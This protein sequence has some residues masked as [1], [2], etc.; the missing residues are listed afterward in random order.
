MNKVTDAA[1]LTKKQIHFSIYVIAILFFVIGFIS[2][3][4]SILIPYF[5]IVCEL[6][7]FEAYFV[8][9]SFYI[10]YLIISFPSSY[11]LKRV[12]YK[13]GIMIAFWIMS[14]GA[15]IFIPAAL[16]RAYG[17][18][19]LG[20]FTL[21]TGLA[22][23]QTA[24]NPYITILG[25]MD[26]AARRI[27][28][29][30]LCN[31]GAGILAPLVF[32]AVILHSID[33]NFFK[34]LPLLTGAQK[35]QVLANLSH[36]L[37]IPYTV[38]GFVLLLLGIAVLFSPLPEIGIND[39]DRPDMTES[40]KRNI[41]DFPYLI[42][43]AIAIFLH[44]GTQVIS[45]DT[46]IGYA[47]SMHIS[48][49]EA[50][51]FPSYTLSATILG[52]LIGVITIPRYIS[53]K[54]AFQVCTILGAVLSLAIVMLK[55]TVVFLGHRSDISLWFVCLLGLANSLIWAGIWPLALRGLGKFTKS[56]ASILIM[57]LCGNALL[58]LLYGR[59]ADVFGLR[60]AYWLLFPCYLYLIFYV[61][62]GYRINKWSI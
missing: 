40:R 25:P 13:K 56:G 7:S 21:G 38:I 11:L 36:R 31:K 50:K 17:L 22:V 55:G 34:R 62:Y 29:M 58:P 15:F 47:T 39:E 49:P 57:A 61:F 54:R 35:N 5:K 37:I 12:G 60:Q 46:I 3:V 10:S 18:F 16:S 59:L 45:I 2:W 14:A 28:L 19:L 4:N 1:S 53:Q 9:F 23:L 24:A 8:T 42:L 30:G 33:S 32:A 48:L 41:F 20:L 52:Y 27:S 6:N 26:S 44:V 43:G 51:I